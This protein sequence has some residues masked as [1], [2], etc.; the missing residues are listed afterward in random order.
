M[1]IYIHIYIY[2]FVSGSPD[3][4]FFPLTQAPAVVHR[5]RRDFFC[6]RLWCCSCRVLCVVV[7][8]VCLRV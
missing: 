2:I 1:Y 8:V 6:V 3:L 7:L 4:V 5:W